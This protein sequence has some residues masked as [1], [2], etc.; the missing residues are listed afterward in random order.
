MERTLYKNINWTFAPLIDMNLC[1]F[2]E[3]FGKVTFGEINPEFLIALEKVNL[4]LMFTGVFYAPH[5]CKSSIHVDSQLE[6]LTGPWPSRFKLNWTN[7]ATTHSRW[8]DILD[9]DRVG[10]PVRTDVESDFV[11]FTNCKKKLLVN[12]NLVGWHL[13]ESGVPHGVV[14]NSKDP[15][16]CISSVVQDITDNTPWPSLDLLVER[17]CPVG[18]R[19]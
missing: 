10:S 1:R 15:R 5:G 7:V 8:Y 11:D 9:E 2:Q 17:L 13:F 3:R 14:N 19:G 6:K 4:K 18:V 12:A 16:W